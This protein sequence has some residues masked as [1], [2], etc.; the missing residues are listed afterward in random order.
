MT[1]SSVIA[2]ASGSRDFE[3]IV[4]EH[5]GMVYSIA[6]H[7]LHDR[8]LAEELAQDVFLQLYEHLGSLKSNQHLRFWLRR[9]TSHRCIDYARRHGRGPQVGLEQ[10]PEIA[11]E[12]AVADPMQASKLRKLVAS[13][14]EKLR[15]VVILRYQ[16]E[17]EPEE[18]AATLSMPVST[19]KSNLQRALEILRAKAARSLGEVRP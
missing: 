6:L 16:E 13:L 1:Q 5:Q 9:V 10:A 8:A 4:R 14:P 17:M 11:A 15:V 2:E 3:Q 19:V 12:E 18:I 7:F